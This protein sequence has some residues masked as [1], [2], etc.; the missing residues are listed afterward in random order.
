[1]VDSF[2]SLAWLLDKNLVYDKIALHCME[3]TAYRLL[4]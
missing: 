2:G 3:E 4:S 1:M